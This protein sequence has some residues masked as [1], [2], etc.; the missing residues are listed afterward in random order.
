MNISYLRESF[1]VGL[2]R[3]NRSVYISCMYAC[4][5]GCV[6]VC[7]HVCMYVCM[8]V[9]LLYICL[10]VC[11]SVCM[12]CM[13]VCMHACES[14]EFSLCRTNKS[15]YIS[16][17]WTLILLYV[18]TQL[19]NTAYINTLHVHISM[20]EN[21]TNIYTYTYASQHITYWYYSI[22]TSR[23]SPQALRQHWL[24]YD[25]VRQTQAPPACA[26]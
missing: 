12:I 13:Y 14:F 20:H 15:V 19:P 26:P 3:T 6:Y 24:N 16:D 11:M 10:Y 25:P 22:H 17:T 9:C 1:K 23:H 2:C 5:Y 7:M 18:H 4:I 21:H 8:Y